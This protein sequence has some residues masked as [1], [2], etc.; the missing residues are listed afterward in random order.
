MNEE[1]LAK[2]IAMNTSHNLQEFECK[3]QHL[4]EFFFITAVAQLSFFKTKKN[5]THFNSTDV[6][7]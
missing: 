5:E 7:P 4:I 2:Q 3:M 6:H 1:T